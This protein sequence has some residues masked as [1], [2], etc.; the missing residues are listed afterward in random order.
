MDIFRNNITDL[1]VIYN[2]MD[3]GV[4]A[5]KFNPNKLTLVLSFTKDLKNS[6]S[7]LKKFKD[8][9]F[10]E[11]SL[12]SDDLNFKDRY[13]IEIDKDWDKLY[14]TIS[15]ILY[16]IYEYSKKDYYSIRLLDFSYG[17]AKLVNHTFVSWFDYLKK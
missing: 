3:Y 16:E 17:R 6:D 2:D 1:Q 12:H 5:L 7:C 11:N 8:S 13:I 9:L 4:S 15:F 14:E 10:F